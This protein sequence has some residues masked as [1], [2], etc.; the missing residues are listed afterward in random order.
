MRRAGLGARGPSR[1]VR[2]RRPARCLRAAARPRAVGHQCRPQHGSG[3]PALG[4]RGRRAHG[5]ELRRER[6]R[7]ERRGRR[8][9]AVGH[10]RDD[11]RRS[12]RRARRRATSIGAE[13]QR[14]RARTRAGERAALGT[15]GRVR[16]GPRR[17][18]DGRVRRST[19]D[20]AA[21]DRTDAPARHGYRAVR[22]RLRDAHHHRRHRGVVADRAADRRRD[23]TGQFRARR[24]TRRT[25]C[26]TRPIGTRCTAASTPERRGEIARRDA[27]KRELN[28]AGSRGAGGSP[29]RA[30]PTASSAPSRRP[31]RS[32]TR[33]RRTPPSAVIWSSSS[34]KSAELQTPIVGDWIGGS[35]SGGPTSASGAT[36]AR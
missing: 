15:T 31:A 35:S 29:G 30:P 22:G 9:L 32:A 2:A 36:L 19:A 10:R 13:P 33:S 14:A 34:A 24:S 16:R 11:R 7:R 17:D 28:G 5:A 21:R 25:P 20:R 23:P 4:H 26:P 8:A 18:R 12:D 6:A 27:A 3:D 1:T